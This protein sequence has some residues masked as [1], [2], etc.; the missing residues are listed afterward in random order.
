MEDIMKDSI[1]LAGLLALITTLTV[2]L[3]AYGGSKINVTVVNRQSGERLTPYRHQ[4]R[5]YVAGA[6]GDRYSVELASRSGERLLAVVAID[7][8]NVLTGQTAATG[9]TGYVLDPWQ[10][11]GING[12][13]KSMDDVAQF[14]FTALPDSYA[15]RTGRPD[16]VG[17]IGVAVYREKREAVALPGVD[18]SW[19]ASERGAPGRISPSRDRGE[20]SSGPRQPEAVP[21][22]PTSEAGPAPTVPA[23][24]KRSGSAGAGTAADARSDR[25]R[26][27]D[28]SRR[29]GTGH[30]ERERSPIRYTDFV[31]ASDTPDELV[32][33]YYDSRRNLIARGI[34]P[35]PKLAEP[36][37]FP[38][39]IGFVPD[40]GS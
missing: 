23:M 31:R 14:V 40:P 10:R 28:E 26:S 35:Q 16:N 21:P 13:R 34:I 25:S 12:W 30:G 8:V 1:R 19:P 39:G 7:G 2:P 9:Q 11:F 17:V 3:T 29:L 18:S 24:A 6:P 32:T 36:T 22:A 37:P 38:A 15:A 33:I 20:E 5:L 27:L 4:G